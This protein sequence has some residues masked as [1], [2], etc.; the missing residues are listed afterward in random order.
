MVV[1]IYDILVY[2]KTTEDHLRDVRKV[3]EK[4]RAH[5]LMAN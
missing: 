3:L 5:K 2:S 1:Y 4:L